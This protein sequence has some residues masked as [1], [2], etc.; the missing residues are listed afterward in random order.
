MAAGVAV[1]G[2]ASGAVPEIIEDGVT[3]LLIP[4][5]DPVAMAQAIS[6]ILDHPARAAELRAAGRRAV[7][8]RFSIRQYV[9]AVESVY[10]K[11]LP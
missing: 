10:E 9:C 3:G 5:D 8:E 1:I 4:P 11:V 7:E 6:S 2:A